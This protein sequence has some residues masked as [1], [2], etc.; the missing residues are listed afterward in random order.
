MQLHNDKYP[1]NLKTADEV[2]SKMQGIS[3]TRL[4][5]YARAGYCPH[6]RVLDQ[7]L[8]KFEETRDWI[9]QNAVTE[10]GGRP[11][12]EI[13]RV[14]V[15]A[16]EVLDLPPIA[17]SSLP[18]Q[19]IA[20]GGINPGVYFLCQGAE[21][22]YIGQSKFVQARIDTHLADPEKQFDRAYLMPVPESELDNV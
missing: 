19:Q 7:L 3:A 22:V 1:R 16:A 15:P 14:C 12:P 4:L 5:D 13:L 10:H 11:L 21:I 9:Q 17:I 18:L 20:L 8:F 2:A 6:F